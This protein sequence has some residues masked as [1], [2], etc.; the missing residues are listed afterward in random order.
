MNASEQGLI[1]E[2]CRCSVRSMVLHQQQAASKAALSA[3]AALLMAA[4][5]RHTL[6]LLRLNLPACLLDLLQVI[7]HEHK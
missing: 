2:G 1:S 5:Y 3:V 4:P 7:V 6:A